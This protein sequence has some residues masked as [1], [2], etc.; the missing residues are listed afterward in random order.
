MIPSETA[1]RIATRSFSL[2]DQRDFAAAS[3]DSNPIHVDPV[4][5]RRLAFAEPIVHGVHLAL[6]ALDGVVAELAAAGVQIERLTVNFKHPVT[7]GSPVEVFHRVTDDGAHVIEIRTADCTCTSCRVVLSDWAG[8]GA[9]L[10][11]NADEPVLRDRGF[12]ELADCRGSFALEA[13]GTEAGRLFPALT[14]QLRPDHLA[15]I[16]AASRLV[17]MECPG[18]HSLFSGLD[19]KRSDASEPAFEYRCTLADARFRMVRM[20][21]SAVDL[22]GEVTAFFRPPPIVQ[23]AAADVRGLVAGLDLAGEVALCVG[24]SRGLGEAMAKLLAMAGAEVIVTYRLGQADAKAVADDIRAAGG[25]CRT[26]QLDV[27]SAAS[28]DALLAATKDSAVRHFHYFAAPLIERSAKKGDQPER[29]EAYRTIFVT[30][31]DEMARRLA[32]RSSAPLTVF[33]PSTAFLENG[34]E[35]FREYCTAKREGEAACQRL[36]RDFTH[37]RC[38]APRLP[39]VL[40]DQTS[41][42]NAPGI[43]DAVDALVPWLSAGANGPASLSASAH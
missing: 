38:I 16:L 6:W 24:G 20:D 35:N 17:G 11:G 9:A 21:V 14:Q 12:D 30:A 31:F 4:A 1:V 33:Y 18:L 8:T 19:L 3:G 2:A 42:L 29:L 26:L 28:R 37:V 39:Q 23:M 34:G 27:T 13:I 5:A 36:A 25:R 43:A 32:E 7:L 41:G 10:A 22:A 15:A 40:T